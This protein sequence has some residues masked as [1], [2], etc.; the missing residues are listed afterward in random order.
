MVKL[1]GMKLHTDRPSLVER[2]GFL[3]HTGQATHTFD[4][5]QLSTDLE[6][7]RVQDILGR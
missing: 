2:D 5:Q 1:N 4:W 3:M 7:E 6:E